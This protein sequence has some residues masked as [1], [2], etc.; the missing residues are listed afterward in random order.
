MRKISD[1][2]VFSA[3]DLSNHIHRKHLTKLN[4]D[5]VDGL[6][7]KPHSTN[8]VLDILRERGLEFERLYLSE[9]EASGNSI[10][11]ID[12]EGR[13]ARMKTIEAMKTGVNYIYQARLSNEVWQ[14]WADFLMRVERRS[15]LG[16]WS[17]E[18][19]DTKL[20]SQ[21]RAGTILQI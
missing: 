3:S 7:E 16:S 14:G 9:L 6:I 8:H 2:L 17:Y 15:S 20:A 18:V 21:T 1:Q 10:I 5:V 13:D 12:S 19:V 11:R 4:K